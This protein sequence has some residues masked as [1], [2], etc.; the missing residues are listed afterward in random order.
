MIANIIFMLTLRPRFFHVQNPA[1]RAAVGIDRLA[2]FLKSKG[3]QLVYNEKIAPAL[4]M[5]D[6]G[7]AVDFVQVG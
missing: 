6:A 5:S 2:A 1:T 4:G 3:I 7:V